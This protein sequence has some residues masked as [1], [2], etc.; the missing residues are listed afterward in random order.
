MPPARKLPAQLVTDPKEALELLVGLPEIRVLGVIV[1]ATHVDLHIETLDAL[2]GCPTCGVHQHNARAGGRGCT[3]ICRGSA[4]RL[5]C[6]GTSGD[7]G[8]YTDQ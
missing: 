7:Q 8:F 6:T 1:D 3:S 4:S 5:G 2:V